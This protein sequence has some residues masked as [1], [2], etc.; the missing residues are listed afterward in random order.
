[1]QEFGAESLRKNTRCG[2]VRFVQSVY[3]RRITQDC[4]SQLP[5]LGSKILFEEFV[6][7]MVK[8]GH[9][10]LIMESVTFELL[11][12]GFVGLVEF[13]K[14]FF[15]IFPLS[16][17]NPRVQGSVGDHHGRADLGDM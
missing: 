4:I 5:I 17:R 16:D 7:P 8:V 6:H 2:L 9:R 11:E 3:P 15:K 13:L 14:L 1:M 12:D 10:S